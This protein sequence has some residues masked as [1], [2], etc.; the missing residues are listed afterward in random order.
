M[1]SPLIIGKELDVLVEKSLLTLKGKNLN[2]GSLDKREI[3][4][5]NLFKVFAS[6]AD[7]G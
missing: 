1:L 6:T 5:L 4:S 2:L 7:F 3:E